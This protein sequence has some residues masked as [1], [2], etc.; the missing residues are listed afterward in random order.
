MTVVN[1]SDRFSSF[2]VELDISERQAD[3]SGQWYQVEPNICAKKPPGDRTTFTVNLLRAPVPAYDLTIAVTV[4]VLSVEVADLMAE[5]TFFLTIE[6]PK[7]T[8]HVYLPFEDLTVY[9]GD[10]LQIPVLLY[11]LNPT[12]RAVTLRIKGVNPAWFPEG[13]EQI[14]RLDSGESTEATFWCAPP[15]TCKSLHKVYPLLVEAFDDQG[16]TASTH[17]NLT[18]LPFGQV[19]LRCP[20]PRQVIPPLGAWWAQRQRS[21]TAIFNLLLH[22]QGNLPSQLRWTPQTLLPPEY[23]LDLPDP[24]IL[25]PDELGT[26]SVAVQAV[27]SWLGGRRT[28]AVELLPILSR[29]GSGE[30]LDTIPVQPASQ[31]LEVTVQPIIPLALQM[32]AVVFVMALLGLAWWLYPRPQHGAPV[33]ALTLM[34]NGETVISGS[35]DQTLRRWQVNSEGWLPD[36]RRLKAVRG[37]WQDDDNNLDKAVRV[38]QH[39]PANVKD[40]AVGLENGEIQIWEVAEESLKQR[41]QH[42]GPDRVFALDFTEDSESLF[43]GH[44]SG[45]VRHWQVA[46]SDTEPTQYLYPDGDGQFAIAALTVVDQSQDFLAVGG[47][48]NRLVLWQWQR[49]RAFNVAYPLPA[50]GADLAFVP[51]V[52]RYSYLTS[53]DAALDAPVLASADSHG[54]ITLWDTDQLSTCMEQQRAFT[55]RDAYGNL[56]IDLDIARDCSTAIADQWLAGEQGQ[57]VRAVSLSN[58]GCYLASTGD[59]GRVILWPLTSALQ[60]DPEVAAGI[61]LRAFA[62]S[63]LNAIDIHYEPASNA[64]LVASD[65]PDNRVQV[66]RRQVKNNGCR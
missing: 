20:Y 36:I 45:L 53:L 35:S 11:N 59:D 42:G 19:L 4:R 46:T 43:S 3:S 63:L 25:N 58:D 7:R 22:N 50:A 44:G 64:V 37:A 40:V 18:V 26:A 62:G 47:Q 66:Y 8:L 14:L 57:A 52:S 51:V 31:R 32:A 60:R 48:F 54:W 49:R 27:R 17:G 5:D 55:D 33:T 34:A 65:I 21:D 56:Y 15:P 13:T 6:R 23:S 9:P 28:W 10:R 61:V 2:Q 38:M 41:F 29:P 39:L 12:A 1:A 24:L 30:S 16:N